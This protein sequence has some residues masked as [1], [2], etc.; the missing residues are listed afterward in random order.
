MG[1]NS[2]QHKIFRSCGN[3][4]LLGCGDA[5]LSSCNVYQCSIQTS[6]PLHQCIAQLKSCTPYQLQ[7]MNMCYTTVLAGHSS[8]HTISTNS[9]EA[10]ELLSS[11]ELEARRPDGFKFI[12]APVLRGEGN[13]PSISLYAP[14][15]QRIHITVDA[16]LARIPFWLKVAST[17]RLDRLACFSWQLCLK[18]DVHQP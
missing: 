17:Q 15:E 4:K 16:L 1:A 3:R 9:E 13:W 18:A 6:T 5:H 12:T 11:S 14:M 10:G 7:C 2:Q 8:K